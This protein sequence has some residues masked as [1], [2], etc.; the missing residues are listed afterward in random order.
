M[1]PGDRISKKRV[2]SLLRTSGQ[3][4]KIKNEV[5]ECNGRKSNQKR[6]KNRTQFEKVSA[7]K[8]V[9]DICKSKI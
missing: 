6:R 3:Q 2:S 4:S 7:K 8:K 9:K 5:Q 1:M